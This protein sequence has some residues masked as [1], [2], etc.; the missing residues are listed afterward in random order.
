M[1]TNHSRAEYSCVSGSTR[2]S[3]IPPLCTTLSQRYRNLTSSDLS[4]KK[5]TSNGDGNSSIGACIF[6]VNQFCR[7]GTRKG[8]NDVTHFYCKVFTPRLMH[9]SLSAFLSALSDILPMRISPEFSVQLS[10]NLKS[11][12][13]IALITVNYFGVYEN[14]DLFVIT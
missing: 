7:T 14:T 5:A 12:G 13:S 11:C 9:S 8:V 1:T 3:S 2:P 6:L 4:S 10:L